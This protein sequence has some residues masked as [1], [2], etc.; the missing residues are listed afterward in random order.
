MNT[1]TSIN[2]YAQALLAH[3]WTYQYSDDHKAWSMGALRNAELVREANADPDK[4]ELF[5]YVQRRR[6]V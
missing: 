4:R 3:D 5:F 1:T 6:G 2:E